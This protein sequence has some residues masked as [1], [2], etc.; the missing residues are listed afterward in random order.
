L[1]YEA[2]VMV[3]AKINPINVNSSEEDIEKEETRK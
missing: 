2:Q 3:D 1:I